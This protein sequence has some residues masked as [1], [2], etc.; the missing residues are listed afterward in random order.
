MKNLKDRLE[1]IKEEGKIFNSIEFSSLGEKSPAQRRREIVK[2][3]IKFTRKT[4]DYQNI[5]LWELDSRTS[6]LAP[7]F[8][9]G[10]GGALRKYRLKPEKFNNGIVGYV[11]A[12]GYPYIARDLSKD[13]HYLPGISDALSSITVPFK[14][15][16]ELF[17]VLNIESLRRSAFTLDDIK[18]L[19]EYA[20]YVAVALNIRRILEIGE[21]ITVARISK[22]L[23][24]EVNNP[25]STIFMTLGT[26][27]SEKEKLSDTMIK[28]LRT[29]NQNLHLIKSAVEK[30]SSLDAIE[31]DEDY[32]IFDIEDTLSKKKVLVIEDDITVR[33]SIREML[34][35]E[36]CI[37]EEAADGKEGTEMALNNRYEVII[38]DIKMPHISGY[39]VFKKIRSRKKNQKIIM[40]TG[41]GYDESHTIVKCNEE[42][43]NGILYK[44]FTPEL[45]K[46]VISR[47][48][49]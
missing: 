3:I 12:T 25:L 46:K 37:T 32:E 41:F 40:M 24:H 4:L 2:K 35:D 42:G 39:E 18:L 47:V 19:S 30:L 27:D 11:A 8:S 26:I 20:G 9:R 45:L 48:C 13:P 17:G 43:L 10:Y 15:G 23:A 31:M 1:H 38:T 5:A 14:V 36:G 22:T 34:E 44:P 49:P 21:K 16:R 33:R 29:I 6:E 7:L 28:A